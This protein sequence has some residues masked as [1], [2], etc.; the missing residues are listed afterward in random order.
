MNLYRFDDQL[1][2]QQKIQLKSS[3]PHQVSQVVGVRDYDGDGENDVLVYGYES[4][5]GNRTPIAAG[6]SAARVFH[7]NLNFQI[8][9]QDLSRLIKKMSLSEGWEKMSGFAVVDLHRAEAQPYP[10]M[11]LSNEI[12]VYNY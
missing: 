5:L 7:S 6:G 3:S 1:E 9:S 2:L 10:F 4:L 12:I 8:Y 11:V